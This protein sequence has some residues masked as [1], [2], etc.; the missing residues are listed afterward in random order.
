MCC[1]P[2][3]HNE[4]KNIREGKCP[5]CD[6]L[7]IEGEKVIES[8]C[9]DQHIENQTCL[10][11]GLVFGSVYV[12][13]YIDFYDIMHKI[14]RKSVYKR[15]YHIENVLNTICY[16][17]RVELSIAQRDRIYKIFDEIGNILNEVNGHR[18]RLISVTFI[19][20]KIF[21]M[22]KI[23]YKE[24]LLRPSKSKKTLAFYDK[25]WAS[26]MSHIGDKIRSIIE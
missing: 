3:V 25:Y 7:L 24:E 17:N 15:L 22:M 5:F 12:T 2:D 19:I 18:K 4:L 9:N 21:E 26:I 1:N 8:C 13:Q 10:N 11:C 20:T 16:V 14:R 6:I 23:P